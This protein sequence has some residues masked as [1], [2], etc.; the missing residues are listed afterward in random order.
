VSR[1]EMSQISHFIS[2]S[3]LLFNKIN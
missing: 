1:I 2:L 3:E